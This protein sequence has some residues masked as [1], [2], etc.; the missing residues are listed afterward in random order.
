MRPTL[1]MAI[2]CGL[3]AAASVARAQDGEDAEITRMAKEHYKLGLDAFKAAKYPEAIKELKKAY[4]LKRLPPL[5]INI[6]KTYEKM[7][8]LD[9]AIYYYKKYLAEAPPDAKDRDQIKQAMDDLTAQ[10]NGAGR[11]EEPPVAPTPGQ[12]A[13][14]PPPVEDQP[15]APPPGRTARKPP[16]EDQPEA[17][18]PGRTARKPPVEDQPPPAPVTPPPA[19]TAPMPAEWTHT[20][21]DSVPPNRPVDVR[22]QTPVMKGVKVFLYYRAAGQS[23][24]T[25]V[26]MKRRGPEK[27]ARI[28]ASEMNGKS[29]QYYIEAKDGAG[30]V[31]KSSGSQ[32]DPNIV[33]IDPSAPPQI[34]SKE[35]GSAETE[36]PEPPPEPRPVRRANPD[37]DND[38]PLVQRP[39]GQEPTPTPGGKAGGPPFSKVGLIAGAVTAGVGVIAL[40]AGAAFG[41][42]A[43]QNAQAVANDAN[44]PPSNGGLF[45]FND[46]SA[47]PNDFDFQQRG[48]LYG[49]MGPILMGVGGAAVLAGGIILIVDYMKMHPSAPK[50]KPVKRHRR[51]RPVEE[52]VEPPPDDTRPETSSIHNFM[53]LPMVGPSTV[54]LGAGFSF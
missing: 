41:A 13:R 4:V 53:A 48:K 37:E 42:L 11:A 2:L 31:V 45:L 21:L 54:G 26:E 7:G 15:E 9:N 47:S 39:R 43:L 3:L 23:D 32:A 19:T 20:P 24:F 49:L 36:E 46:P 17:P 30:A 34:A 8:D 50:A 28:P 22:V 5:L 51:R 38:N 10:K 40:A 35:P 12:T 27:I 29:I 25:Q 6:A 44:N 1:T 16:V 14:K 18:P 33:M 52:P